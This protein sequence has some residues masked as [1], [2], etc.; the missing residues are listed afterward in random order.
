[1]FALFTLANIN[2]KACSP[3]NTPFN[4]LL[5]HY[6]SKLNTIVEGYFDAKSNFIVTYSSD[7]AI[8]IGDK[9]KVL[10]YGPFGSRCEMYEMAVGS[11]FIGPNHKR[12]LYLYKDRSKNGKLVTPIFHGNGAAISTGNM[13]T[14]KKDQYS[15]KTNRYDTF[16][17]TT[18]LITLKKWLFKDKNSSAPVWKKEKLK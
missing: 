10:E 7:K 12:L 1:M 2:A 11:E 15:D 18:N 17:L 3:I 5:E 14:F 9:N 6:D 4:E 16:Q 8:K 13:L